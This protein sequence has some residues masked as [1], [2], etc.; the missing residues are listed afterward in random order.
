MSVVIHQPPAARGEGYLI[1]YN[2]LQSY[3]VHPERQGTEREYR[4]LQPASPNT[5]GYDHGSI[6]D[7]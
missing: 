7:F 1:T 5:E 2:T 3:S 6:R 4:S